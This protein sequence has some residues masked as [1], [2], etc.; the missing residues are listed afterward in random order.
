MTTSRALRDEY[1]ERTRQA[2]VSAA[3]ELFAQQGYFATKVDEVAKLSRVSPATI[4]AQCGG[5]QGLL[6]SLMDLW[7]QSPVVANTVADVQHSDDPRHI[8][9]MMTSAYQDIHDSWGDI[10]KVVIETAP[11]DAEA[12]AVLAT[13]AQRHH[14]ALLAICRRL[15]EMGALAAGID[16]V[17][18][19]RIVTFYFGFDGIRRAED[20]LGLSSGDAAQWLLQ[21]VAAVVLAPE[22]AVID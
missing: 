14:D 9:A 1:P 11:H 21:Q 13:A 18:A 12:A 10:T 5:K 19:T 15:A 3:R 2:A 8:L 17:E 22:S 16:D 20:Y 4:Y 6:R 7:T